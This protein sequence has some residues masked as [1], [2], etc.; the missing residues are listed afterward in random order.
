MKADIDVDSAELNKVKA[1]MDVNNAKAN[2]ANADSGVDKAQSEKKQADEQVNAAQKK[3]DDAKRQVNDAEKDLRR[4]EREE[5]DA[6]DEAVEASTPQKRDSGIVDGY[7]R[8]FVLK[9][10]EN[11]A[12]DA[13]GS[14][15]EKDWGKYVD[16]SKEK[17]DD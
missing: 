1:D 2:K 6:F 4:A 10:E 9:V 12:Q 11:Y 14:Y 3:S 15:F 7:G 16:Y 5:G 13:A 17:D 8:D